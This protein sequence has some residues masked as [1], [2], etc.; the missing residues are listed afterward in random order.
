MTTLCIAD[1][2]RAERSQIEILRDIATGRRLARAGGA[3]LLREAAAAPSVRERIAR[4]RSANADRD[5]FDVLA[6]AARARRGLLFQRRLRK[7][8]Q[9]AVSSATHRRSTP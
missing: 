2:P 8:T 1:L 4:Y 5:D 6:D 9:R 3:R 7:R